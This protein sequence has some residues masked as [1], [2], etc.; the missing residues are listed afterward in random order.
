M[1]SN[2]RN[3]Q[4]LIVLLKQYGIRRVVI[5]AGTRHT[6]FVGS[7]E[8]DPWF[9]TY[10]VVDERGASFFALGL[11]ELLQE[12]AAIVCTSGTAAAN[13]VSAANEA[14]YQHLPL[15]ILTAD[16]NPYYEFQQEE[17]MIP[18]ERLFADV[19]RKSVTL[20]HVRD[21]K[22][23]W[24]C[25]RVCSEA[26]LELDHR[27]PGPV[28]I[29][30]IVE[31][32]YPVK[33]GI[34]R[35]E[36]KGLPPVRKIRR[37][38]HESPVSEWREWSKL[39]ASSR[40]LIVYGQRARLGKEARD[41]FDRFCSRCDC[42]VSVDLLSNLNGD[43]AVRTFAL[44]RSMGDTV[45]EELMPD[46]VITMNANTVSEVKGRLSRHAGRFGHWHVSLDGNVSDPF[47]CLPDIVECS[48]EGFF[49]RMA[50]L[51]SERIDHPFRD[52][53]KDAASRIGDEGSLCDEPF[54]WSAVKVT[55]RFM[56]RIPE[57]AVLHLANSNT[58]RIANFFE[59][60]P[61]VDVFCNRGCNG[62]D[63]SMSSY[64]AQSYV[65]DRPSYLLIGDLSFFY[66]MNCL[67]TSYVG[68]S[69]RILVVNNSGGAIFHSY[70][71][72]TNVPTLDDHIAAAHGA[73]VE[74][75]CRDRGFKYCAARTDEELEIALDALFEQGGGPVIVEA[76]TDK[77][78]DADAI[79]SISQ[80]YRFGDPASFKSVA[81]KLLPRDAKDR[82]KKIIR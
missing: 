80:R 66:D 60:A 38:M 14:F 24:Y 35:F 59:V 26:L 33:Q 54:D 77:E 49:G 65:S 46:L 62:I 39:L 13:Y 52:A 30:F 21:D 50:E 18:Q 79:A 3:V 51:M 9:E 19:I 47:K 23:A 28:H 37:L 20:P 31:N 40:V 81:K 61:S 12:P 43:A 55:Q 53:W 48:P 45:L 73:S 75:W 70:P 10:S 44:M 67:W 78:G 69:T 7:I 25:A 42:A 8:Q 22:D 76:F 5:S 58:V 11:I 36:E 56:R 32:D 2:L 72:T 16:R 68:S 41:E 82:I 74:G 29:N 1:Y 71:N 34:V 4:I 15:V 6:P 63:G 64:L 57:N 17:Q 27:E